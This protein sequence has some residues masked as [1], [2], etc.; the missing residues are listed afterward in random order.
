MALQGGLPLDSDLGRL[1][2]KLGTDYVDIPLI[3]VPN[4][5]IIN[6]AQMLDESKD[7][8]VRFGTSRMYTQHI[9]PIHGE[10]A[11]GGIPVWG[12]AND[13]YN[14]IRFFGAYWGSGSSSNSGPVVGL[15]AATVG[16]QSVGD[17]RNLLTQKQKN[18]SYG[19]G[20]FANC[21]NATG[22]SHPVPEMNLTHV[23]KTGKFK[24]THGGGYLQLTNGAAV[25]LAIY[26]GGVQ[27]EYN[28]AQSYTTSGFA[29]MLTHDLITYAT[30]GSAIKIDIYWQNSGGT[31]QCNDIRR[32]LFVE[33]L[34]N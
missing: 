23:T 11:P 18:T 3:N 20:V 1:L 16:S 25:V 10:S 31:A 5:T 12:V 26:A 6:R 8:R 13:P 33:D 29:N 22:S 21:Q 4:T 2:S 27:Q 7:I 24:V 28:R 32:N 15:S 14:A 17:S 9:F 34:D 30:P 19:Q